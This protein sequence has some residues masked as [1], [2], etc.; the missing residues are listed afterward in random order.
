MD[1]SECV[2]EYK[3]V[4][5]FE[6]FWNVNDFSQIEE[7]HLKKFEESIDRHFNEIKNTKK[8]LFEQNLQS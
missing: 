4:K 5:L 6:T 7:I 2:Q 1:R 8:A 3:D